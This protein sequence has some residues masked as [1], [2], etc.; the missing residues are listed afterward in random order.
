[1]TTI[2][3][4][5]LILMLKNRKKVFSSENLYETIWDEQYF[6]TANN[7]IMVHIRNLRKKLEK[8][9]KN[10]QYIKTAWGKGYYID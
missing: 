7:T 6:Y 2:E 5:I 1:M 9:Q 8:D 10:P 3:Y 4:S